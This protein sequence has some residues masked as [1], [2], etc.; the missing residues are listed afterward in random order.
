MIARRMRA[1]A[2]PFAVAASLAVATAL[3]EAGWT[4]QQV[5]SRLASFTGVWGTSGEDVHAVGNRGMVVHFDGSRWTR[6]KSGTRQHLLAVWA[7]S[8][9]AAFAVGLD[10]VIL[11]FDGRGWE[12]AKSGTSKSLLAV[13]GASPSDVFAV[14]RDG[15]I[16][17]FDGRSWTR[18][19]SGTSVDLTAV[20][21]SS[22]T[23]VH[24]AGARGTLLRYDGVRWTQ[25]VPSFG[26][27]WTFT[28]LGG[29][30]P[31]NVY[32][33]GWR[34]PSGEL[35]TR[36]GFLL[37]SDGETWSPISGGETQFVESLWAAAPDE[38]YLVGPALNGLP[39]VRR[40]DGQ[41]FRVVDSQSRFSPQAIWGAPT[42]EIFVA[43]T[44]GFV[45]TKRVR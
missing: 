24:A 6:A 16:L 41:V 12:A 23:D 34:Q 25:P 35:D 17:H 18:Q 19:P 36:E 26:W 40:F 37:R 11:H 33:A 39:E 10:G 44:N 13:W 1:A 5:E 7:A 15:T 3:P 43:G 8:R 2:V 45:L 27:H 4:L 9:T 31:A 21:G 29:R 32:A 20:W 30:S 14:G 28:A 22:A 38:V 42:G